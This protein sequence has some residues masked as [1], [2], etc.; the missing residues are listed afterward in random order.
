MEK[1]KELILVTYNIQFSYHTEEIKKNILKMA[2]MGASIF[3]LQEVVCNSDQTF[4]VNILLEKLGSDWK[5]IHNL[6]A[7][8]S[9]LEMGNCIIWNTKVLKLEKE[10]KEFLPKH[11]ALVVHEKIFSWIVGGITVPFQRRVIV[12]YFKFNNISIR[13][14]NI[15]LDQNGGL[16]NRK[17]QLK[18]LANTLRKNSY[19]HEIIC[20]DF[21]SFDLLKTGKEARMHAEILSKDFVD[22]S[23]DSGWTADLNDIDLDKGNTVFK[24]LI[25]NMRI[26]IRR[27]LDYIW[28]KNI[29]SLKCEKLLLK[30]SDHK[31]LISCLEI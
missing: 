7:E 14:T 4:I 6:G 24:F 26:H 3:C 27:K 1:A 20:G 11:K 15:H 23:K 5:A 22:V 12:G 10:Q 19:T 21:N 30:G 8:N 31:P 25:K 16:K 18:Y 9:K 13:I 17:I 2:L 29:T 28:A